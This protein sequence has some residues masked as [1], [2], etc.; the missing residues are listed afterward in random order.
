MTGGKK[1]GVAGVRS[2]RSS[3][4]TGVTGVQNAKP[5]GCKAMFHGLNRSEDKVFKPNA[6]STSAP[7]LLDS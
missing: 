4:V 3:G 5:C 1:A 2:Y 6:L 7:E